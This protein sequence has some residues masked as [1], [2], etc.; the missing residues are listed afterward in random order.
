VEERCQVSTGSVRMDS[1][2]SGEERESRSNSSLEVVEVRSGSRSRTPSLSRLRLGGTQGDRD[3]TSSLEGSE[4]ARGLSSSEERDSDESFGLSSD[5]NMV[6]ST[7]ASPRS[8]RRRGDDG[9]RA[10]GLSS[11]GSQ[12][13]CSFSMG[14][15]SPSRKSGRKLSPRRRNNDDGYVNLIGGRAMQGK[16]TQ[17]GSGAS[18]TSPCNLASSQEEGD[19]SQGGGGDGQQ[20]GP[21]VSGCDEDG[22]PGA[23]AQK[24]KSKSKA[25]KGKGSTRLEG[26]FG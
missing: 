23:G 5:R 12:S 17:G 10:E 26:V 21:G 20:A 7:R 11:P 1:S 24:T 22:G 18:F 14:T 15:L 3:D 19:A 13:S 25:K 9:G 8:S 6:K 2:D 4:A 16:E